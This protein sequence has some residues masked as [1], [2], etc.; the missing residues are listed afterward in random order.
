MDNAHHCIR[1]ACAFFANNAGN[2]FS[3]RWLMLNAPPRGNHSLQV[4]NHQGRS[5][6]ATVADTRHTDLALLLTQHRG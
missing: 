6:A 3:F 1:T 4:L 2:P 5:A